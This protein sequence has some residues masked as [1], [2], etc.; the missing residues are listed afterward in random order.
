MLFGKQNEYTHKTAKNLSGES[1]TFDVTGD[2][3]AVFG[4][5]ALSLTG[6][7]LHVEG[8]GRAADEKRKQVLTEICKK[9]VSRGSIIT[10]SA[11]M[12]NFSAV[13]KKPLIDGKHDFSGYS[14]NDLSGDVASR[15]LPGCD[16]NGVYREF[17]DM[18]ADFFLRLQKENICVLFRP[19]HECDGDWFWWGS[20][21]CNAGLLK[22]LYRYTEEYLRD[23]KGVHNLI[24]VFS[25]GTNFDDEAGYEMRY[26]GDEYVDI[27]G[28]DMYHSNPAEND[29]WMEA[30][31]AKLDV[32]CDFARSHKKIAA[33]TE[34]G[35]TARDS[36]GLLPEGNARKDWFNEVLSVVSQKKIAYFL[37]WANF[38]ENQFFTPYMYD[39]NSGHEMV[40]HF[41]D[42][43]AKDESI[44][45]SGV[46]EWSRIGAET[47]KR[48]KNTAYIVSPSASERIT[49]PCT[50]KAIVKTTAK[51]GEILLK[52]ADGK[53]ITSVNAKIKKGILSAKITKKHLALIGKTEGSIALLLDGAEKDEISALFNIPL[54]KNAPDV[55]DDFEGYAGLSAEL[56]AAYS[57]NVG[58]MCSL[59]IALDTASA[60]S[61]SSSLSFHY[62]LNAGGY[63]GIIKRCEADW[64]DFSA[65]TFRFFPDG[66]SKRLVIQVGSGGEEFECFPSETELNEPVTVTVPFSALKGKQGGVFDSSK[67]TKFCIYV[68]NDDSD[69][70][71]SVFLFDD[72][73]LVK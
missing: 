24:Y 61:D 12:P 53:A 19:F 21:T 9:A 73:K 18:T 68:N 58:A 57:K 56:A 8:E 66:K 29:S 36:G 46:E 51:K 17:L 59:E 54:Q 62:S 11:H 38:D 69:S 72:I 65:I 49:S 14:P 4:V 42:F 67:I 10:V 6:A 50:V 5:D 1:D 28:F 60:L 23:Q 55:I 31:S 13:A 70:V 37:T 33:L 22:N 44:F 30:L 7:E 20:A 16:L 35:I 39:E 2:Y 27:V 34:T 48:E 47:E 3:A 32:L 63:C 40:E 71:D 25:P 45:A 26:P 43:Y 64:S 52:N 41:R 15:L